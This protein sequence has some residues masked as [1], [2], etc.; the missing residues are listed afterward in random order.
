MDPTRRNTCWLPPP[1][2]V[3]SVTVRF[4]GQGSGL[5]RQW[6]AEPASIVRVGPLVLEELIS[7]ILS[8]TVELGRLKTAYLWMPVE[9]RGECRKAIH[10][11]GMSIT[12]PSPHWQQMCA[13]IVVNPV[14]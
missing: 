2:A 6:A 5:A 10:C 8:I 11:S 12:I 9:I 7:R 4:C 13:S 3:H 1:P 14:I